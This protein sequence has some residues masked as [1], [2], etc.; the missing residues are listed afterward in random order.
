MGTRESLV[1]G[2]FTNFQS[3]DQQ[4]PMLLGLDKI[5]TL[6]LFQIL[7]KYK[8]DQD[9]YIGSRLYEEHYN[10]KE[11][12]DSGDNDAL[13]IQRLVVTFT[14]MGTIEVTRSIS[15]SVPQIR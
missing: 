6:R 5:Y 14:E 7:G 4:V 8:S 10:T 11:G 13:H 1:T 3:I 15:T 12:H 2:M 9:P